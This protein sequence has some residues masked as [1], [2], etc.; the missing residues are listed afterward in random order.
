MKVYKL[1]APLVNEP[2]I[3]GLE[4]TFLYTGS[5]FIMLDGSIDDPSATEVDWCTNDEVKQELVQC[6][7]KSNLDDV[8]KQA[9]DLI[10][11]PTAAEL[12]SEHQAGVRTEVARRILAQASYSTQMNMAAAAAAGVLDGDQLAAFREGLQWVDSMRQK[13]KELILNGDADY[14]N[15]EHWPEPT[16]AASALA[17]TF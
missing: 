8:E 9:F 11:A 5:F 13:G 14:Q 3:T 1:S 17:A 2:A 12:Q 10:T 6:L 4:R 7:S 16:E 15:D